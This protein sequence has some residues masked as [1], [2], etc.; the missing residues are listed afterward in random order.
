VT[1]PVPVAALPVFGFTAFHAN[2]A[3]LSGAERAAIF[4]ESLPPELQAEA[5]RSL[6]IEIEQRRESE[7]AA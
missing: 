6:R 2:T 1:P 4:Y 7:E 3:G 5:W